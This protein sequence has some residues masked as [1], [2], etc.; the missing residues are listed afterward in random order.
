MDS[1]AVQRAQLDL[2]EIGVGGSAAVAG[3]DQADT[4]E[5]SAGGGS[6]TVGKLN[7]LRARND[8]PRVQRPEHIGISGI[9]VFDDDACGVRLLFAGS[10]EPGAEIELLRLGLDRGGPDGDIHILAELG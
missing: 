7:P 3:C 2:I 8:R 4:N 1:N 9:A 10:A 6:A 5:S